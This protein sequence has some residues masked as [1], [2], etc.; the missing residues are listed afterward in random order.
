MTTA[1]MIKELCE[2][3]NISVSELARRIGQTP[4]NFNKKLKRETVTLDELKAIAD[5]LCV[6]FEQAFILPEMSAIKIESS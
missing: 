5:V 6:K 2:Q 1:E 3:M 4:Q